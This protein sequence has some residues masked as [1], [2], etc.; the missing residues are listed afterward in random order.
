[1]NKEFFLNKIKHLESAWIGHGEFAIDL[2]QVL[3]PET[4]VELG[5]DWGYST[6]CFAYPNIGQVYGIDWFQG[7]AHT[8]NRNTE[9]FVRNLHKELSEEFGFDNLEIIKSDF[10]ELSKLWT[11]PIDVL[12][13]DGFHDYNAV[14]NDF[15]TWYPFCNE[16]AV[17]LFHDTYSFINDVGRF[18]SELDGYKL[19][20]PSYNGLGVF[21][22]SEQTYN[23]IKDLNSNYK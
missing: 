18:F 17:V 19:N 7:D 5:V 22:K 10:N 11:R 14:K 4:T 8:S 16:N 3:N 6:F 13:I 2:I 12:H 9:N 1:M 21:T 15:E 20:T 23:L